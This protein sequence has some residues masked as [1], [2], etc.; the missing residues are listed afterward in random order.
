VLAEASFAEAASAKLI[1]ITV[2][3]AATN[4]LVIFIVYGYWISVL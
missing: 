4:I 2:K 3:A 1:L